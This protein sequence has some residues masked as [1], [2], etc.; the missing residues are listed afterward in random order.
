VTGGAESAER[1][2]ELGRT[3]SGGGDLQAAAHLAGWATPSAIPYGEDLEKELSR[4]KALK[5]KWG[6][7]NGAGMTLGAQ[8]QMAGWPTAS[9]RDWKDTPGMATTG[10]NPDGS[11]R[12]RLDQ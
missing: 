9:S 6:N 12:T 8:A 5:E 4:R 7:G 11:E 10:V 2:Q 1:K 3:E